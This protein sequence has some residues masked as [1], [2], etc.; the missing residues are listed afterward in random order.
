MTSS[1]TSPAAT[2]SPLLGQSSLALILSAIVAASFAMAPI[3]TAMGE[4]VK[5][6]GSLRISSSAAEL[7]ASSVSGSVLVFQFST[8]VGIAAAITGLVA[9]ITKRGR[10][11]GA[12]AAILGVVG[13]LV[14]IMVVV[15][16]L[17]PIAQSIS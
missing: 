6:T 2:Q 11:P 17:M 5:T 10:I 14:P 4:Y 9:A 12:V 7:I 16:I 8:Y 3:A 15:V 13:P 1:R